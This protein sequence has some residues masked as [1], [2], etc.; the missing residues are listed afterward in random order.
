VQSVELS[1]LN[2]PIILR[3]T[4]VPGA[5]RPGVKLQ[6]F[7]NYTQAD[8]STPQID[9]AG[10]RIIVRLLGDPNNANAAAHAR[11]VRQLLR[12][13]PT[14]NRVAVCVKWPDGPCTDRVVSIRKLNW[15]DPLWIALLATSL[16]LPWFFPRLLRTG[17]RDSTGR[18][19]GL[20]RVS[21]SAT[22]F[23]VWNFAVL[24]SLL[25][26]RA[27]TGEW[28]VN[29]TAMAL[30]GLGSAIRGGAKFIPGSRLG[31]IATQPFFISATAAPSVA[32]GAHAAGPAVTS[33]PAEPGPA[34]QPPVP[35]PPTNS[36]DRPPNALAAFQPVLRIFAQTLTD[37]NGPAMNRIQ[38]AGWT[39]I[40][41]VWYLRAVYLDWALPEFDISLIGISTASGA[42]HLASKRN[43]Q[44]SRSEITPPR[45]TAKHDAP[46]NH[47][48]TGREPLRALLARIVGALGRLFHGLGPRPKQGE[49]RGHFK[50]SGAGRAIGNT[51]TGGLDG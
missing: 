12:N 20:E 33:N 43:E 28:T 36:S 35:T 45:R 41:L 50:Q 40:L 7:L 44:I 4:D 1:D 23:Y 13:S 42:F 9:P 27:R 31:A 3:L 37:S 49:G 48:Q 22:I 46:A 34:P 5:P 24:V 19:T 15:W 2:E 51:E 11:Q 26:L 47:S 10:R 29:Q 16:I 21:L 14:N 38:L 18:R 17:V 8:W 32:G 25:F 6:V 30:L 39:A